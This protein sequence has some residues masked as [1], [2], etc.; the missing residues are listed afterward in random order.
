[1]A[2]RGEF[3][4]YRI[5]SGD[6]TVYIGKG[7]NGRLAAQKRRFGLEGEV[8]AYFD[9]EEAAYAEEVRLIAEFAPPMNKHPGGNGP[10]GGF[11]HAPRPLP[12]GFTP[13]GLVI[14][15]PYLAR[16][17]IAWSRDNALVGLLSVF[18]AYIRAH[19]EEVVEVAILP[20]LRKAIRATA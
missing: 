20:H 12:N 13:E 11:S 16:L 2:G 9:D 10:R 5:F 14:A 7:S 18:G 8:V 3:Y 15:A 1:M 19:G 6:S 4:V 17:L